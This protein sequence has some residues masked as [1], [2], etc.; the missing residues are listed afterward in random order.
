MEKSWNCVFNFLWDT[1]KIQVKLHR[2]FLHG[3]Q[4]QSDWLNWAGSHILKDT[5]L[6]TVSSISQDWSVTEGSR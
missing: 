6:L 1:L 4:S 2:G 3:C 5:Y